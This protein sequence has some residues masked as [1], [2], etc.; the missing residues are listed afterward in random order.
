MLRPTCRTFPA[1]DDTIA[2]T[3]LPWGF[4]VTPLADLPQTR[5][6][7]RSRMVHMLPRCGR[8]GAYWSSL[9][10]VDDD[11]WVCMLCGELC[12][13][14]DPRSSGSASDEVSMMLAS[15]L[16]HP[17]VELRPA[18]E[19][20]QPVNMPAFVF[21]IVGCR[22]GSFLRS[23]R[24]CLEHTLAIGGDSA[25]FGLALVFRNS[26]WH[27]D[28]R[29]PS[30]RT[31]DMY[32]DWSNMDHSTR[33]LPVSA[34]QWLRPCGS[35]QLKRAL[36]ELDNIA[37]F[38]PP[39]ASS[40]LD[41]SRTVA[42]IHMLLDMLESSGI[43]GT[44]LTVFLNQDSRSSS[45]DQCTMAVEI[46]LDDSPEVKVHLAQQHRVQ[47]QASGLFSGQKSVDLGVL[48]DVH[49]LPC[50]QIQSDKELAISTAVR[51]TGGI[52]IFHPSADSC[53]VAKVCERIG[54]P[55]VVSGL[56]RLRTTRGYHV[57]DAYGT[58]VWQDEHAQDVFH[59]IAG[60]G[61]HSTV[62][63]ELSFSAVAGFQ[64]CTETPCAQLAF[65]GC[66]VELGSPMRRIVRVQTAA[67]PASS[68]VRA[69][70]KSID[71]AAV[72]AAL[73]Y[74][75]VDMV[76]DNGAEVGQRWFVAWVV[77]FIMSDT[78]LTA[79]LRVALERGTQDHRRQ[80][81]AH[82]LQCATSSV[83][84][85]LHGYIIAILFQMD[86]A[87][88]HLRRLQETPARGRTPLV[89]MSELEKL[90]PDGVLSSV[91]SQYMS[92]RGPGVD[93]DRDAARPSFLLICDALEAEL[94]NQGS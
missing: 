86:D 74:Q 83:F 82:Q 47:E 18:D 52:I 55:I 50:D 89:T 38:P 11:Q 7:N 79:N 51:E 70:W 84:G 45:D 15:D 53:M 80:I 66:W 49:V 30:W 29:G 10:P 35:K 37:S 85:H 81:F 32:F 9:S 6:E 24:A 60:H 91:R 31:E 25:L 2:D 36:G 22:S 23:V 64:A 20:T 33:T 26:L 56:L 28:S 94:G 76:N 58:C 39:Y 8:C 40:S 68:S 5:K 93:A 61:S 92:R 46:L 34:D 44:R 12:D 13:F 3:A 48:I 14:V 87:A 72:L 17:F 21:L 59:I 43:V 69:V 4:C 57:Q 27:L 88:V 42:G 1:N 19:G 67:F 54:Q 16:G 78:F 90:D 41:Q 71:F 73:V 77:R 75:A 62:Y 63:L 65:R